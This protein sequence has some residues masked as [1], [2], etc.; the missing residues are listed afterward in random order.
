MFIDVVGEFWTYVAVA[1]NKA[2]EVRAALVN[3]GFGGVLQAS[4]QNATMTK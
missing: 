1:T 4:E 2:R 3:W